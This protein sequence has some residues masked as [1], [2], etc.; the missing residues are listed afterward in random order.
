MKIFLKTENHSPNII[1]VSK[2]MFSDGRIYFH[3][4]L[5]HKRGSQST[6]K[7][8]S[9]LNLLKQKDFHFH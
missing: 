7:F 2:I 9:I 8:D 1:I 5:L 4:R 3:K 6:K